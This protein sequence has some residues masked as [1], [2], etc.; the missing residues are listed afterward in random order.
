MVSP[1][2]SFYIF[3]AMIAVAASGGL[4]AW[5]ASPFFLVKIRLQT[6]ASGATVAV[7][8]QHGYTN[9]SFG[10][11]LRRI[12]SEEGV[13]GLQRGVTAGMLRVSVGSAAQ[14]SSYDAITRELGKSQFSTEFITLVKSLD[15]QDSMQQ[16]SVTQSI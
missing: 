11:G 16:A 10:D 13:A 7:G 15:L 6:Q 2:S 14:L 8:T 5:I 9:M 4:S 3:R 12:V 1:E